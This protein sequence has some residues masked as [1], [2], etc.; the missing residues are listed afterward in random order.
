LRSASA[1]RAFSARVGHA[2]PVRCVTASCVGRGEGKNRR[3]EVASR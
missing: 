3:C 2:L 1:C